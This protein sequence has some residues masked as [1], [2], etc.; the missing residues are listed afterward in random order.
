M[1]SIGGHGEWGDGD[2]KGEW[3]GLVG[4]GMTLAHAAA[5]TEG[6]CYVQKIKPDGAVFCSK[7]V[8]EEDLLVRVDSF[9]CRGVPRGVI[10]NHVLGPPGSTVRLVRP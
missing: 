4:V 7:S 6:C 2:R 10:K 5:E 3:D 8:Q 9:Q 1:R